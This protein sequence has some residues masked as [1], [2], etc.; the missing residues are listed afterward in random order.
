MTEKQA[1]TAKKNSHW[2]YILYI[3]GRKIYSFFLNMPTCFK[4]NN[5]WLYIIKKKNHLRLI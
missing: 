4:N 3:N 5:L 1:K 2:E